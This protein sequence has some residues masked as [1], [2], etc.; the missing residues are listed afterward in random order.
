MANENS[1]LLKDVGPLKLIAIAV[2]SVVILVSIIFLSNQL[3]K[4]AV[5]PLFSGLDT[6][7]SS[8]IAA[9]LE[10]MGV[11]YEM[12]SGGSQIVVQRDKVLTARMGLAE[13][14]LPTGRANVGYELFDKDDKIGAS[15]FVNDVNLVRALEG[16]LG[17]TISSFAQVESA[18]V[19]IV[20]PRKNLF[21]KNKDE[22]TAS[23]VVKMR[24][25]QELSQ[26][27]ITG[28]SHLVATAV[29]ELTVNRITIV[30][31]QGRPLKKGASAMDDPGAMAEESE[32]YR[33]QYEKRMKNIIEDIL[34]RSVGAGKVEAQVSAEIDFDKIVINSETYDPNGQVARSVQT[35]EERANS[36][37]GSGGNVTA[38]N[39][40][41]GGAATETNGAAASNNETVNE[42]T[43]YEISKT[44]QK[45]VK[46]VGNIKKLSIAV[47]VDG[48]YE[49]DQGTE[50]YNYA[51]RADDE[52]K[53]IEALVKSA[54]GYDEKRGDTVQ[55]VNMQFSNE[56]V[57]EVKEEKFAWLT[58][59]F[60]NIIQTLVIGVVITLVILLI[61]KPMVSRA[62]EITK[63]ESE[64]MELQAAL[65]GGDL[66]ELAELTGVEE[67]RPKRENLIDIEKLEERMNTSSVATIN[68]IIARHPEEAVTIIRNWIEA[69]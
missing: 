35:T 60:T 4:P 9:K 45:Q 5:V 30:D 12:R 29:P 37:E 66:E 64:E 17:R 24:G 44:T 61:V 2:V 54:V 55:V 19:H 49:Y 38:G 46:E 47:L 15:S 21:S 18:R 68:D 62:F 65:A 32:A 42:V 58:H 43:N 16:E 67:M 53:K 6:Q 31:T 63:N 57:S 10:M 33:V 27:Q 59:D 23:V 7:D 8:K 52:L 50:T 1:Q 41:P 14:G 22:A 3:S 13:D 48:K 40:I 36:S 69:G 11:Y 26:S 34:S 25:G 56:I 28:I 20:M 51:P 39:N